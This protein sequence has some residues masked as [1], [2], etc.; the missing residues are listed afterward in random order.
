MSALH[1]YVMQWQMGF[2]PI[3]MPAPIRIP[4]WEDR[5]IVGAYAGYLPDLRGVRNEWPYNIPED[6]WRLG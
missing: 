3:Q 5:R 6:Q 1:P 2:S 4:P